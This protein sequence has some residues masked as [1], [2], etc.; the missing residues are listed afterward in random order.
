MTD[1]H[2][3]VAGTDAG[4]EEREVQRVI[5][6]VHAHRIPGAHELGEVPLEVSELLAEN[7]VTPGQGVGERGVDLGL[8]P[9]VVFPRIHER[10]AIGQATLLLRATT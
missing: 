7:E 2:D 5:S 10:N 9:P 6:A 8:E 1:R 4:G 3:L